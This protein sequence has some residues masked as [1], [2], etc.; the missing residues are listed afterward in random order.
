MSRSRKLDPTI[1]AFIDQRKLPVGCY[2][3]RRDR[4]WY[5]L[6]AGKRKW[7]ASKDAMLSDLHMAMETLGGTDRTSLD[8]MLGKFETSAQFKDLA[9][10]T[11][12]DYRYCRR[13]LQGFKTKLGVTF[14]ELRRASITPPAIQ[15][16]VDALAADHP[17][18]ANHVKR[19]LSAAYS[20]ARTGLDG[21]TD[22]PAKGVRQA[23]ER[24]AH[25]TPAMDTMRAFVVFLRERGALPSRSAGSVAPYL[26]AVAEISYRCRAR[27]I[28]VRE[29]TDADASDTGITIRRHKGSLA[30]ITAWCP[31]LREAWDWLVSRRNEIWRR[32]LAVVP[33]APDK[34]PIV[35]TEDGRAVG[36]WTLNSAWRRAVKQALAAGVITAETRFGLHGLKHRGVTDTLGGRTA[37]QEAAGHK[38]PA[39]SDLYSHELDVV[40]PAGKGHSR[41]G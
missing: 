3:N 17:T 30:N 38:T 21:V 33:I 35:V 5:S 34:R 41:A 25:R 26:W 10:S 28:E 29:L 32:R 39:M 19:Y 20:W 9:P 24:A 13:V 12:D 7:I 11:R 31:E 23:K 2:W 27:S 14:A 18:K 40:Q 16:L 6:P 1:P 8:Y 4:Y 15:R 36:K 22:N 37:R